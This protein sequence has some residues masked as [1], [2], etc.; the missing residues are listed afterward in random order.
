MNTE[1]FEQTALDLPAQ[2]R[3]DLAHKLLLSLEEQPQDQIAMAW[4]AEAQRRSAEI[5]SGAA[6]VVPSHEVAH[7]AS[8]L[9]R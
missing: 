7:A 5:D 4:N 6:D 2:Q 8:A 9:L 3:A 1:M